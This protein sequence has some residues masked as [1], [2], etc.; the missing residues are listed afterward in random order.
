MFLVT[1]VSFD[2]LTY[3]LL[4]LA[5]KLNPFRLV[6]NPGA[7]DNYASK[8]LTLWSLSFLGR[9]GTGPRAG[10]RSKKN[11]FGYLNFNILVDIILHQDSTSFLVLD[12][13]L[14]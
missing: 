6:T 12:I 5:F 13:E 11:S 7:F 4:S 2:S 1:G 10:N 9:L 8:L 14:K 3:T